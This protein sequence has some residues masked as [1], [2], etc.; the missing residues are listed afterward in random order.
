MNPTKDTEST[1]VSWKD[2]QFFLHWWH[3]LR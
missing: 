3:P 2:K 1:R